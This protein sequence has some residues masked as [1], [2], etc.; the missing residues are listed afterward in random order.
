MLKVSLSK[1]PLSYPWQSIYKNCRKGDLLLFPRRSFTT[2]RTAK[3][4]TI[5]QKM[6]VFIFPPPLM[7]IIA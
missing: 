2:K 3:V 7:S 4:M 1:A 6:K 5:L